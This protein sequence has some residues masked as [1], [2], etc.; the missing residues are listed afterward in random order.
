M[1]EQPRTEIGYEAFVE[2][3]EVLSETPTRISESHT[4]SHQVVSPQPVERNPERVLSVEEKAAICA[5][6]IVALRHSRL[7]DSSQTT[8]KDYDL[9]A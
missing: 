1:T 4:I 7:G 3:P 2:S 9:A 5:G 8:R 6:E